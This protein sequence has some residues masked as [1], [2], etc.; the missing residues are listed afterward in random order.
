MDTMHGCYIRKGWREKEKGE[1]SIKTLFGG[2]GIGADS[3][4]EGV[5]VVEDIVEEESA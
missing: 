4:S 2:R 1:K 5:G 3:A